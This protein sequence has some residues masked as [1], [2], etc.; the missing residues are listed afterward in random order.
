RTPSSEP[1]RVASLSRLAGRSVLPLRPWR[2]SLGR[3]DSA[4]K[5]FY[6]GRVSPVSELAKYFRI[7]RKVLIAR[8]PSSSNGVERDANLPGDVVPRE[9]FVLRC[10]IEELDYPN[11]RRGE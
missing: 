4:P 10:F 11:N 2:P 7:G 5:H 8:E 9:E 6:S 3:L 1:Y